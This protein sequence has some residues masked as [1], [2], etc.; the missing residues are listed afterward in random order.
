MSII[1]AKLKKGDKVMII[2]PSRGLKLIGADCRKIA[3]ERLKNWG[4]E[5]VFAPNTTDENFD[6]EGSAT[7]A[8]RVADIHTAFA[9]KSVKGIFTVIG[10]FNS[11]QLVKHL[12]Y[13]LIAKNPKVFSGF[14]DITALHAAI[15]TQTKMVTYYGPHYSSLGMLKGC[16]YTL[17]NAHNIL[18][19]NDNFELKASGEWADDAWYINQEKR[20]FIKNEGWWQIGKGE[21]EGTIIGGNLCTFNLHLGTKY[22]PQFEKN[23]ILFIEDDE[24][25]HLVHF[26]RNLQALLNQEDFENV[27]GLVIGRFQKASKIDRKALEFILDKPELKDMP[28]IANV[29]MGHTT[30]IAT[31]PLGGKCKIKDGRIF[32]SER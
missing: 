9:D 16:D 19:E 24:E 14:S 20:E 1:P 21:A 18:F 22:R 10:G 32:I 6:M 17:N 25:S 28:I 5:V 8:K 4:L 11:N 31:I 23:T 15:Y 29:D 2:A 7:V 30:P 13:D 26:E 3:E 12:D 27:K